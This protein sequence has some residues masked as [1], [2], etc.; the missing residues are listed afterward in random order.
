MVKYILNKKIENSKANK[1]NNI[2]EIVR[3]FISAIYKSGW[4]SLIADNNNIFFRYKVSAKFTPKI[5][6][7]N[8][9]KNKKSKSAN[10]PAIFNKL[11]PP[12]LAK[13]PKEINKI[14]KYFKKNNQT[15]DKKDQRKLYA[16]ASTL[17]NKTREVIKEKFPNLQTKKIE[18]IQ[19]II[20]D[21]G[22]SKPRLYIITKGPLRK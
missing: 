16:Q 3:K 20:N 5:N 4:N 8:I 11:P 19:K 7:V 1:I 14:S 15:N 12:I 18:N 2:G 6:E 13:L 21:K 10:K 22:K 17:I 9:N